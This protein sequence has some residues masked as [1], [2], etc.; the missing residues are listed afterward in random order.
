MAQGGH[1][2][3]ETPGSFLGEVK[4]KANQTGQMLAKRFTPV[5]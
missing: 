2:V 5:L 1:T 4:T 3:W